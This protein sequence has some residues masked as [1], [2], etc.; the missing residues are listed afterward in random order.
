[1]IVVMF[2]VIART[3][4]AGRSFDTQLAISSNRQ[5]L[6][7]RRI[8]LHAAHEQPVLAMR[9]GWAWPRIGQAVWKWSN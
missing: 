4:V 8:S 6:A 2:S 3:I 9:I 7:L 5:R 1:M